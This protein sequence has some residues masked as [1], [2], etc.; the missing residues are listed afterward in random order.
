MSKLKSLDAKEQYRLKLF[1][2]EIKKFK[3]RGTQ[4]IS[5]YVPPTK[6]IDDV[7]SYLRNE[8]SE[9]SNI[10]SK[11]TR[12]NV[13]GAIESI[14]SRLK[15]WKTVPEN[16]LVFF[17]GHHDVGANQTHMTQNVIEPPLPISTFLYR[18][19]SDFYLDQLEDMLTSEDLYGLIVIDRSEASIGL[20]SGKQIECIHTMPSRVPSKHGKGGQS[21]QR[22]ERL[23]EGAAHDFFKKVGDRV[24]QAFLELEGL[25]GILVGGPGSTKNYFVSKDFLHHELRK[26]VIDTFDTGYTNDF[27]LK[28]L[29]GNAAKTMEKIELFRE[30]RLMERFF[31]EIRKEHGGLST[32]GIDSVR[33]AILVGALATLIISEGIRKDI[34]VYTCETD[35]TS[36]EMI[37]DKEVQKEKTCPECRNNMIIS[38]KRDL[39]EEM[40]AMAESMG[41]E[42]EIISVA[43]EEGDMLMRA[44]GGVAGILRYRINN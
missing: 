12:K 40:T 8:F 29:A 19:D 22:F 5:L 39:V 17:V 1:L 43:S 7:S 24:N 18:C 14:L 35:G 44:F 20:I 30:K 38:E 33:N 13:T 6:R 25:K 9:S 34:M 21:A 42:V 41:T 32:Y 15:M 27:G 2:E 23:I 28:E 16:G 36:L 4:L 31:N 26:K 37:S 3:G 10:K 11:S